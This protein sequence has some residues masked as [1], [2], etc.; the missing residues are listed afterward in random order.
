[1][2]TEKMDKLPR[3]N[4]EYLSYISNTSDHIYMLSEFIDNS[5]SSA[6]E[7]NMDTV[8]VDITFNMREQ[9]III[10]DDAGGIPYKKR[11]DALK[12]GKDDRIGNNKNMFGVGMKQASVW[13]GRKFSYITKS[14]EDNFAYEMSL[15]IDEI[16]K[17]DF[18]ISPK[19][20]EYADIY[21]NTGIKFFQSNGTVVKIERLHE[22]KIYEARY[23]HKTIVNLKTKDV[24]AK[25]KQGKRL[26]DQIVQRYF[27]SL[28]NRKLIINMSYINKNGMEIMDYSSKQSIVL[29]HKSIDEVY[30]SDQ[31]GDYNYKYNGVIGKIQDKPNFYKSIQSFKKKHQLNTTIFDKKLTYGLILDS[32]QNKEEFK[33]NAKMLVE[34]DGI[35]KTVPITFGFLSSKYK[36]ANV[37]YRGFNVIQDG[38]AI[39]SGPNSKTNMIKWFSYEKNISKD[40]YV[41]NNRIMGDIYLND[42]HFFRPDNNKQGF[43]KTIEETIIHKIEQVFQQHELFFRDVVSLIVEEFEKK[44]TANN[45]NESIKEFGNKINKLNILPGKS[46]KTEEIIQKNNITETETE[47]TLISVIDKER[48]QEE[49]ALV[50]TKDNISDKKIPFRHNIKK[51]TNNPHLIQYIVVLNDKFFGFRKNAKSET[52]NHLINVLIK[53]LLSN[54]CQFNNNED[55]TDSFT[56]I[57]KEMSYE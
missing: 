29:N 23:D 57:M 45:D 22:E 15:D 32:L 41:L 33:F 24:E 37:Q 55:R 31:N 19:T 11:I 30:I 47:T 54:L 53:L 38:R 34:F 4:Q 46:V 27:E 49:F 35:D 7:Y 44:E 13:Y 36:S 14:K 39:I 52:F 40:S 20:F 12:N 25:T 28:K 17:N 18:N 16:E 9:V 48:E 51:D 3:T 50:I 5:L 1:M 21:N 6:E 43:S 2:N 56:K 26:C 42:N 8:N 10:M